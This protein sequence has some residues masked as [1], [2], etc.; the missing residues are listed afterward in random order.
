MKTIII[1]RSK[2]GSTKAYA[3]WIAEAVGGDLC[4]AKSVSVKKL[5]EYDTIIYGGGL[6]AEKI[7]GINFIIKS[8]EELK[9]KNIIVFTTGITPTT[10]RDY[11]DNIN[12]KGLE[13]HM[14][15]KIKFYNYP[16]KMILSELSLLHKAMIKSLKKMVSKKENLTEMEKMLIDMCSADADL[17]DKNAIGELVE[18]VKNL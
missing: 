6:Y 8:Y 12:K 14:I 16:G 18:Y 11:Y 9:N 3:T 2:Y 15:G 7:K 13:P 1:Y 17:T 10:Y 4:K 5:K